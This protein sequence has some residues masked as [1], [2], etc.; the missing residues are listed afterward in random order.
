MS[1]AIR[2]HHV[3]KQFGA[4]HAAVV[5][6]R[7][8][9]LR[10]PEAALAVVAGPSGSGK[11]TLLHLVGGIEAPTAGR[12]EAAGLD[13]TG[14]SERALSRYRRQRVGF[15]FQQFNLLGDLTVRE[16][17]ELPLALNGFPNR[18]T[19]VAVLLDR[20]GLSDRARAFPRELSA[21]E[22]QRVA[23]ARGIAHHPALLL[24]DEPTA[25]LDTANAREVIALLGELNREERLTILLTTHD[26]G[27]IE[28]IPRRIFLHDGALERLE[29]LDA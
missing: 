27:V 14:R 21:G 13:L 18:A 16:N 5:A 2:F 3:T 11:T 19:R 26:P 25:N 20:L 17:I 1:H 6:L 15:V 22:Q 10:V 24:A 8:V 4:G 28:H 9:S 29:G 12:V 7:G 23:I